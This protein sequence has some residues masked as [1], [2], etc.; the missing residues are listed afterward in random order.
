MS[1]RVLPILLLAALP[2]LGCRATSDPADGQ[3]VVTSTSN[4]RLRIPRS[5]TYAWMEGSQIVRDPRLSSEIYPILLEELEGGLQR[6]GY[7]R[8]Q[9]GE[10]DLLIGVVAALSDTLQNEELS[11]AYGLDE[12][13]LPHGVS[14]TEYAP[15]AIVLDIVDARTSRSLWRGSVRGAAKFERAPE[16]RREHV[17]QTVEALL[18]S[19]DDAR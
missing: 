11:R 4:P 9:Y 14:K 3:L 15:G 6:R 19:F 2:A 10:P 16:E 8:L 5:G 1:L 18:K 17:R 13:W 7:S 12:A